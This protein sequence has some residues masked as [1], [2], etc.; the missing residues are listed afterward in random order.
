[1]Y[2]LP[3]ALRFRQQLSSPYRQATLRRFQ[4]SRQHRRPQLLYK[5]NGEPVRF[6][7]V[8][9]KKPGFFSSKR[10][11]TFGIYGSITYGGIQFLSRYLDI[12]IEVL[13]EGEEEEAGKGQVDGQGAMD[14]AGA[15]VDL[16]ADEDSTFIPMTWAQKRPRTYYKGSDPEWQEFVKVAKDKPRHRKILDELV[17]IVY[18]GTLQHP[19]ISRQLGKDTKIGKFWLDISFP[20]GP[21][22]EYERSGLEIGDDFIAWSQ[23][24]VSAENQWR[25]TRTLWPKAAAEGLWATTKVLVGMQWRRAK[26]ALG[27]DS[28]DPLSPEERYRTAI[29]VLAKHQQ[30]REQKE[31]GKQQTE[32]SG[33]DSNA[34]SRTQDTDRRTNAT[35]GRKLPWAFTVPLPNT[36]NPISSASKPGAENEGGLNV[37]IPIA[38]HVFNAALSKHWKQA[39][40][41]PPRGT[42]VVQGLVEVRGNRGRML[43]DVQSCYDPKAGK[44]VVVNAG[45][46]NYKSWNQS[47][48]GGP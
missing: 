9:F 46:R 22:Q 4:T 5:S 24:K 39:K 2:R 27:L 36:P 34:V 16:Y 35:E 19:L 45:V 18:T 32:P 38:M 20:D 47:P 15:E 3:R 29:E 12:E 37:D 10:M 41:E 25:L 7:S 48:K 44:Y 21:P 6:Q 40:A 43:F 1:M 23:Q 28:R 33:T 14:K 17:Q 8:R 11:M 26:Q 42:F 30:A 13:D 31:M